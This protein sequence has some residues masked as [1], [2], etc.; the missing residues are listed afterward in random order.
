MKAESEDWQH[1]VSLADVGDDG[2]EL[3]I[4]ADAEECCATA[5]I[6]KIHSIESLSITADV[7]PW[8]NGGLQVHGRVVSRVQQT[9]VV[10]LDPVEELVDEA[11]QARFLPPRRT[12][13]DHAASEIVIDALE[14]EDPPEPMV[15]NRFDL[16]GLA[17]EHLALALDPYPRKEGVQL[18]SLPGVAELDEPD[19]SSGAGVFDALRKLNRDSGDA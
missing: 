8:R 11:F 15:G 6:L 10:T 5:G 3:A 2:L 1:F 19:D 18:D 7:K 16:A 14:D 13:G 4:E 9:C 17:V 12:R